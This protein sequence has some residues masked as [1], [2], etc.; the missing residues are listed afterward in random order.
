MN[1]LSQFKKIISKILSWFSFLWNNKEKRPN[2]TQADSQSGDSVNIKASSQSFVSA[3]ETFDP[4]VEI[5]KLR[6]R[7]EEN[8]KK[9]ERMENLVYLGFVVLIAMLA[10]LALAYLDLIRS[11]LEKDN[12]IKYFKQESDMKILKNCLAVSKWLNP[13]CFEN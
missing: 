2:V 9:S 8:L 11:G 7:T 5:K 6:D 3:S 4:Y 13:K 10:T 12:D 1:I